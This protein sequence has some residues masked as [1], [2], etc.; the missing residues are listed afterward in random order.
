MIKRNSGSLFFALVLSGSVLADESVDLTPAYGPVSKPGTVQPVKLSKCKTEG[1]AML[2]WEFAADCA[3]HFIIFS[4]YPRARRE[5]EDNWPG[6]AKVKVKLKMDGRPVM[7]AMVEYKKFPG[8]FL[9]EV[10]YADLNGDGK[11][12]FILKT[13]SHGVGLAYEL[14]AGWFFLLSSDRGYQYLS[15]TEMMQDSRIVRFDHQP[16]ATLLLQRLAT[17]SNNSDTLKGSDGKPHTFFTI[18]MIKIDPT[19]TEGARLDNSS[20]ARFPFWA[21]FTDKPTHLATALLTPEHKKS[22]WHDPLVKASSGKLK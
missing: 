21:L 1:D 17:V 14:G 12:D 9:D 5:D 18:D 16:T 8:G 19:A 10:S 2:G 3:G 13:S 11:P 4:P 7:Q 20:D 6:P 22:L 15:L